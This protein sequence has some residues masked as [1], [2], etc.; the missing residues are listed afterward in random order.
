MTQAVTL[1]QAGNS[2]GTF[3]NKIINGAMTIDQRNAGASLTPTTNGQY[4]LDR[5]N[6]GLSQSSK[7]TVQQNAGSVTPPP[8]FSTYIGLTV[9]ASANVTVGSGDY[10][11]VGQ[12]IEGYNI[13]DL[14]WGTASAKTITI[15]FWVRSSVTGT[16]GASVGNGNNDRSYPFQYTINS[17]NTWEYKTIIIPGDTTGTWAS[18]NGTGIKLDLSLGMGSTY[19]APAGSWTSGLYVSANSSTNWISTNSATFYLTGVQLEVGTV[20]SSFELRSYSKELMMC[21]RYLFVQYR[22]GA[23]AAPASNIALGSS[24]GSFYAT[25][26]VY[27]NILFPVT[28]RTTPSLITPNRTNAYGYPVAGASL[29]APTVSLIHQNEQGCCLTSTTTSSTTAGWACNSYMATTNWV[30]GDYLGYSAEL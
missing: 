25:T 23:S 11:R 15:S 1:A 18:T 16:Y 30:E 9:G 17:A 22:R 21:Q 10:F 26:S 4:T 8:G 29:F 12:I 27:T 7:F 28:L 24:V 13:V 19:S 3:R 5:W 2:N 20:P 6:V 14:A